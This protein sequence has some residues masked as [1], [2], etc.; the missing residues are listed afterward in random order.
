MRFIKSHNYSYSCIHNVLYI[1]L[2]WFIIYC[3][4]TSFIAILSASS[5][6]RN[7]NELQCS[8]SAK[9]SFCAAGSN[10]CD[11]MILRWEIWLCYVPVPK[12]YMLCICRCSEQWFYMHLWMM[13]GCII[14]Q[15]QTRNNITKTFCYHHSQIEGDM[16]CI[17]K[18]FSN[19]KLRTL[20]WWYTSHRLSLSLCVEHWVRNNIC[21]EQR[22]QSADIQ[23]Y[24]SCVL[25]FLSCV[26]LP[27]PTITTQMIF[28]TLCFIGIILYNN[29]RN[30][31]W[32]LAICRHT[33]TQWAT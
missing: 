14:V 18:R 23:D 21:K 28:Y 5:D 33:Y 15:L 17:I 13:M 30:M 7:S 4:P 3:Q 25:C 6:S 8:S 19:N 2:T 26:C 10:A 9:A 24:I 27:H 32:Y 11:L 12:I 1:K 20:S 16:V 22:A 29:K 31:F